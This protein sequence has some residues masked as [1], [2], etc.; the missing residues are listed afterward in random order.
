M[1][2][3]ADTAGNRSGWD[4]DKSWSS[5]LKIEAPPPNIGRVLRF[6]AEGRDRSFEMLP[7]NRI[8]DQDYAI[9]FNLTGSANKMGKSDDE[10]AVPIQV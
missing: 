5:W 4:L 10:A 6:V 2:F 3:K 8:V 7:L 9:H 1:L